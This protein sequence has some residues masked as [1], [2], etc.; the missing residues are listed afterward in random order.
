MHECR[1]H[2]A[3][4]DPH[5][6]SPGDVD[7]G[8]HI[9]RGGYIARDGHVGWGCHVRCR[10]HIAGAEGRR[11]V[12]TRR[13]MVADLGAVRPSRRY[14]DHF[15]YFHNRM[16]RLCNDHVLHCQDQGLSTSGACRCARHIST[17]VMEMRTW[18]TGRKLL[19]FNARF[20]QQYQQ[21]LERRLSCFA[22]RACPDQS[23]QPLVMATDRG[24]QRK[25]EHR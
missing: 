12:Q 23:L 24:Q 22:S 17:Q 18:L 2:L 25:S 5:A 7:R 20:A 3:R 6:V 16:Y 1:I 4:Q 15:C 21:E 11:L 19:L 10:S 8:G 14:L 13:C 9:A